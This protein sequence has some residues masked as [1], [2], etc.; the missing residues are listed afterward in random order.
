MRDVPAEPADHPDRLRWNA[1]YGSRVSFA[2]HPL[3]ASALSPSLP[4]GPLPDGPVLD[5]A[6]GPSGSGLLAAAAGRQVT[7]VDISEVALDLLGGEAERRGLRELITI[8]QADLG[9]WRPQPGRYALVLCTG[10]WDRAI[11]AAAAAAVVAG[12]VLGWEAFTEDARRVRAGLP[13]EWCLA[14]GEPA[15]LLPAGFTVID[16]HDLPDERH[17][18]KR[19]LLARTGSAP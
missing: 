17:G 8:V 5:L 1:K 11:F 16:Q 7:A 2:A 12:G 13:P 19:R 9:E 4:G 3:A 18:T 6:C 15:S 10:Y 14:P